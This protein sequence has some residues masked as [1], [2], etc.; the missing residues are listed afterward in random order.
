MVSNGILDEEYQA[1]FC[2]LVLNAII[3]NAKE[4]FPSKIRNG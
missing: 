1:L 2:Q 4:R 3:S